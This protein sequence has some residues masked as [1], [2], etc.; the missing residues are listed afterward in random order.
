MAGLGIRLRLDYASHGK[1]KKL[2]QGKTMEQLAEDVRQHKVSL[3]RNVPTQGIRIDDIDMSA[4]VYSVYDEITGRMIAYAPVI[5]TFTADSIEDAIKFCMKEEFR[6]VEVLEP[7]ELTL[8]KFDVERLVFKVS[9][10]LVSYKEHLLKK[11]N[12]WK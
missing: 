7:A 11:I 8:S 9:E 3:L 5:I 6:T 10:E 2:F 4:E 1:T 12:N